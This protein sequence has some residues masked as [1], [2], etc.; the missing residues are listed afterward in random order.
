MVIFLHS[1]F[2]DIVDA[3]M[4]D[5]FYHLPRSKFM[6]N[7]SISSASISLRGSLSSRG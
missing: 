6:T 5:F 3:N 7:I 2:F 1:I 4:R